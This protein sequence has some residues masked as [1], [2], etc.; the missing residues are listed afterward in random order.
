MIAITSREQVALIHQCPVYVI[1][2]IALIP[3]S[4][5][6]SAFEALEKARPTPTHRGPDDAD[7]DIDDEAIAY[8][9]QSDSS[10]SSEDA[11]RLQGPSI[12]EDVIGRKG[13]YGRF[14]EKWFSKR[15]WTADHRRAEGMSAD[16]GGDITAAVT[17]TP[18]EVVD[19]RKPED[20]PES[21]SGVPMTLGGDGA[22][23]VTEEMV[24]EDTAHNLTP[25]LL[26]TTRL[27]LG[28]R[29]FF[30]SYDWDITRTWSTRRHSAGTS[31]PLHKLVDPLVR[32]LSHV[33]VVNTISVSHTHD[34]T[35]GI[36]ISKNPSSSPSTT[37]SSSPSCKVLSANSLSLPP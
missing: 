6:R 9:E 3:L 31:L 28:S 15:G 24:I 2:D 13:V 21:P 17:S 37:T 30:F 8:G 7:S 35:S 33:L 23:E 34:S 12:G 20:R 29:S 32:F 36:I 14:A 25:K 22:E 4:S 27:L 1:T 26:N 16:E 11:P 18:E 19:T 5:R 10:R